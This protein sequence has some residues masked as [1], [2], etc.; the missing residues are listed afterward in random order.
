M[1]RHP[2]SSD[3]LRVLARMPIAQRRR[4][5][6][7]LC[8]QGLLTCT[9]GRPGDRNAS[10]ALAWLPLDDAGHYPEEIRRRHAENMLRLR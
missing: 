6:R 2:M 10:Y 7:E 3:P 1:A 8:E 9:R 4:A 5:L